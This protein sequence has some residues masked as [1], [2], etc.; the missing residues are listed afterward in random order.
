MFQNFGNLDVALHLGQD[1]DKPNMMLE[2][3]QQRCTKILWC[4]GMYVCCSP[5]SL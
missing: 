3:L 4:Q 2:I 5:Y 1:A